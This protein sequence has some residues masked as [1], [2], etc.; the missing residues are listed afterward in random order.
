MLR[1]AFTRTAAA[2]LVAGALCG[3]AALMGSAEAASLSVPTQSAAEDLAERNKNIVPVHDSW[4]RRHGR[5]YRG[6][7][8]QHRGHRYERPVYVERYHY[9]EPY[10]YNPY[11]ALFGALVLNLDFG[12]DDKRGHRDGHGERR[13]GHGDHR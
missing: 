1:T 5:H 4:E 13:G 11:S 6:Y 10:Y 2:G 12:D 8:H 9:S 7:H 3:G